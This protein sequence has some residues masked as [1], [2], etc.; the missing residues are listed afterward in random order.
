MKEGGICAMKASPTRRIACDLVPWARKS[1]GWLE[2]MMERGS[3]VGQAGTH[4]S[5]GGGMSSW[6]GG[7]RAL[8]TRKMCSGTGEKRKKKRK[9]KNVV[10]GGPFI[11]SME[12][13]ESLLELKEA[14]KVKA[15]ELGLWRANVTSSQPSERLAAFERW[16]ENGYH[17]EMS[18]LA[19]EDRMRRR[20][21]L[22]GRRR[23]RQAG[24]ESRE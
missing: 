9:P 15:S 17:G 13:E 16:I 14:M 21:D 11:V 20:K 4:V 3:R 7:R 12:R 8:Q 23:Q 24:R 10:D 19:R 22:S 1:G 18:F 6:L 2:C 5:G